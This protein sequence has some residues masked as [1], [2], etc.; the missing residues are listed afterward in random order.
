MERH[1]DRV[2]ELERETERHRERQRVRETQRWRY[3]ERGERG[4]DKKLEET[5]TSA[6]T[7]VPQLSG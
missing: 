5:G 3:G 6:G 7:A 4:P 2:T 1:K